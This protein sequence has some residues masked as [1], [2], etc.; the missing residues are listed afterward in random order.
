MHTLRGP[1][2]HFFLPLT[3]TAP[4]VLGSEATTGNT[5]TKPTSPTFVQPSAAPTPAVSPPHN[6][7][8]PQ[9][10]TMLCPGGAKVFMSFAAPSQPDQRSRAGQRA[11]AEGS[12]RANDPSCLQPSPL[13]SAY[14]H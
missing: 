7:T 3:W 2:L 8:V 6:P 12:G 1:Q 9:N 14:V 13:K 10:Q 11:G 5:S 4:F